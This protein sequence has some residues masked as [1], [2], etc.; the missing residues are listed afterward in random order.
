MASGK[1]HVR[2]LGKIIHSFQVTIV[3][4][5]NV[6]MHVT[7]LNIF[8]WDAKS[9]VRKPSVQLSVELRSHAGH[10]LSRALEHISKLAPLPGHRRE[11][12]A[13]PRRCLHSAGRGLHCCP[14]PTPPR[15]FVSHRTPS[16][17]KCITILPYK[18]RYK[19]FKH[20]TFTNL[21]RFKSRHW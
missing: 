16:K 18:F 6:G 15:F 19:R 1:P 12:P 21:G 9:D 14:P 7:G 20:G 8:P 10:Y 17:H 5:F 11:L 3:T 2:P 4:T 13:R